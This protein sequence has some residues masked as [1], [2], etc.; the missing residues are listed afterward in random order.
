MDGGLGVLLQGEDLP[1]SFKIQPACLR[2]LEPFLIPV[3]QFQAD[4]LLLLC[5]ILAECRLR[6]TKLLCRNRKTAGVCNGDDVF[7]LAQVH[8]RTPFGDEL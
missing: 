4:F 5:Q 2:G 7:Q 3:K 1:G 6:D 8:I